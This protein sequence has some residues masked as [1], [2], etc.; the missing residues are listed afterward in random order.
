MSQIR[1]RPVNPMSLMIDVFVSLERLKV[2]LEELRNELVRDDRKLHVELCEAKH[3]CKN[4]I[5]ELRTIA[6][7]LTGA[8]AVDCA[9]PAPPPKGPGRGFKV[10]A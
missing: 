7:L 3:N 8:E 6:S 4:I 10:V 5:E 9:P 2:S 1:S